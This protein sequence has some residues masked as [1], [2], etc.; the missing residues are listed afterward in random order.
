MLQR[1]IWLEY[2]VQADGG[3]CLLCM[4]FGIDCEDVDLGVLMSR[5]VA[6]F[7]KALEE[8]K[9]HDTKCT[10]CEAVTKTDHF[11]KVMQGQEEP[12][13]HQIDAALA[14]RV[15][16]NI[17]RLVPIVKT[18]ADKTLPSEAIMTVIKANASVNHGNCRALLVFQVDAGESDLAHHM[19]TS[20]WNATYTSAIIQNELIN[21]IGGLICEQILDHVRD[22]KF[23]S[24]IADEV[25]DSANM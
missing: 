5:P 1:S 22:S 23:Y 16:A 20:P 7:K 25:T 9:V 13:H 21:I 15:T 12:V 17:Q 2:S 19:G 11:M 6:N 24:V 18:V 3:L 4:L 8:L 14:E 10:N